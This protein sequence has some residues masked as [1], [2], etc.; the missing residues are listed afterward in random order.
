[1]ADLNRGPASLDY[2]FEFKLNLAYL[3]KV[4][5]IF[6]VVAWLL[7]LGINFTEILEAL[8]YLANYLPIYG[9]GI[10]VGIMMFFAAFFL[11]LMLTMK[12]ENR[13]GQAGEG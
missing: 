1:M 11:A 6:Y 3:S 4:G 8:S 10:I 9:W 13:E 2:Y 5:K 7:Q 12:F